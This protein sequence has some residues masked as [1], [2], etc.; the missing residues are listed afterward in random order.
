MSG[1]I[2]I[3]S[4]SIPLGGIGQYMQQTGPVPLNNTRQYQQTIYIRGDADPTV[5]GDQRRLSS[6]KQLNLRYYQCVNG[7][8]TTVDA[9]SAYYVHVMNQGDIG[10]AGGAS[11]YAGQAG[12]PGGPAITYQTQPGAISYTSYQPGCQF[13]IG[14]GGGGGGAGYF[15]PGFPGGNGGVAILVQGNGSIVYQGYFANLVGGG[16]GGGGGASAG[17]QQQGGGGGGGATTGGGGGG[18][19]Y[20]QPGQPGA[21]P[22]YTQAQGGQGSNGGGRGGNG[23]AAHFPFGPGINGVQ[24]GGS[25]ATPN[26]QYSGG[27][28]GQWST[29][30]PSLQGQHY[31]G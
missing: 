31:A 16:G 15:G 29:I 13:I 12:G 20:S 23:G 8:T 6:F 3:G 19:G 22:Y 24:N 9:P 14:G 28:A 7:T 21:A 27:A 10:G 25:V 2:Q 30:S 1:Q 4:T 18:S 5:Q 17:I 11:G 26:I